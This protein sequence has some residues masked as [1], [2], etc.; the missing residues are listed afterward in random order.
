MI[1]K[2]KRNVKNK[3]RKTDTRKIRTKERCGD[4]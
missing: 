4:L 3:K 1:S 2:I